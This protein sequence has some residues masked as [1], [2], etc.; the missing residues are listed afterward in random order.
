MPLKHSSLLKSVPLLFLICI[1]VFFRFYLIQESWQ[2]MDELRPDVYARQSPEVFIHTI[3]NLESHPPLYFILA[4]IMHYFQDST[5]MARRYLSATAGTLT[6]PAVYFLT[7]YCSA[8]C[9]SNSAEKAAL[10][11][12]A[13]IAVSPLHMMHSRMARMYSIEVLLAVLTVLFWKRTLKKEVLMNSG[14]LFVI[15]AF[16]LLHFHYYGHFVLLVLFFESIRRKDSKSIYLCALVW[17][18]SIPWLLASNALPWSASFGNALTKWLTP[19][20]LSLL[21]RWLDLAFM[22]IPLYPLLIIVMILSSFHKRNTR[23]GLK[24]ENKKFSFKP[25]VWVLLAFVPVIFIFT[26]SWILQSIFNASIFQ[27]AQ[28]IIFLPF[29]GILAGKTFADLNKLLWLLSIVLIVLWG[30][31]SGTVMMEFSDTKSLADTVEINAAKGDVLLVSGEIEMWQKHV[32][33]MKVMH[34]SEPANLPETKEEAEIRAEIVAKGH[35]RIWLAWRVELSRESDGPVS[36]TMVENALKEDYVEL[37]KLEY[38]SIMPWRLSLLTSKENRQYV[39]ELKLIQYIRPFRDI[40]HHAAFRNVMVRPEYLKVPTVL[41]DGMFKAESVVLSA[42]NSNSTE[43]SLPLTLF[44][45]WSEKGWI[46]EEISNEASGL[47]YP[48]VKDKKDEDSSIMNVVLVRRL[49]I[50][51]HPLFRF[52]GAVMENNGYI[53]TILLLVFY[54]G[55]QVRNRIWK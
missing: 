27:P 8:D 13:F 55:K 30:G 53:F 46:T 20:D 12:S 4:R 16:M 9:N 23:S 50:T 2:S 38:G 40:I 41:S 44:L 5:V 15:I 34:L 48:D 25:D 39:N 17:V 6:V 21:T 37:L 31:M 51:A 52:T 28:M 49:F 24:S 36:D 14:I 26:L 3:S 10:L 7:K 22:G 42:E 1:A 18:L 29:I 19:T 35:K 11:A 54:T 45:K 33:N 32:D 43:L 47:F